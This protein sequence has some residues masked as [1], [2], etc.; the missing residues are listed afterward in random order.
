LSRLGSPQAGSRRVAIA[1]P[2]NDIYVALLG[3]AL[4]AVAIACIL[5]AME[6]SN[7]EWNVNPKVSLPPSLAVPIGH[8]V[9]VAAATSLADYGGFVSVDFVTG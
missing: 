7:Y 9:E 8:P 3:I 5:L 1:K 4:G 6:M 2:K